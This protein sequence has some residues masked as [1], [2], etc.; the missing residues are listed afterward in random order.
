M[1]VITILGT[2]PEIIKL[3]PLLPLLD[4]EFE[5]I[6]VHTGQHYDYQMDKV[7]FEE[8]QLK[9]PKY[10]L[11]VGSALQGEQTAEIIKGI[12]K[13]ILMEKPSIV[14]VFGDTNS[15]L[16]GA[17]AASKMNVTLVHIE[18]GA[19]SKNQKQPEEI[20]RIIAD[21]CADIL[22]SLDE[23]S[24]YNLLEEGCSQE[25]IFEVGNMVEESSLRT[26]KYADIPQILNKWKVKK[27]QYILTT[28]HR[29]EN[30]ENIENLKNIIAALNEIAN[31]I[32]I[33]FPL[34]PRTKNILEKENIFLS[35]KIKVCEGLSH[36]AFI[37]LLSQ[38]R[39]LITD[40]G[41]AMQ[42]GVFFNIPVIIPRTKTE[43]N[44]FIKI[45]KGILTG[46]DTQKIIEN[47]K[48]LILQDKELQRIKEIKFPHQIDISKKIIEVLKDEKNINNWSRR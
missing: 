35:N 34:H 47:A 5:H 18:S 37:S 38:A 14:I 12:E 8:L 33:I 27:D 45:G 46:A 30:T 36:T 48:K 4:Q 43:L 41:G 9:E 15:T 17:I 21:H 26:L 20:N 40:S 23:E 31:E 11:K 2:R 29:A 22:F 25:R 24:T 1:K 6:L 42:E 10:N 39:F 19:R 16:A 28:I 7:F 44:E 13:I 3:S 32:T